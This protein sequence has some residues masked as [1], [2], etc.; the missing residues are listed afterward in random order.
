VEDRLRPERDHK[1]VPK[2]CERVT[3]K[4]VVLRPVSEGLTEA[5]GEGFDGIMVVKVAGQRV[6]SIPAHDGRSSYP[7]LLL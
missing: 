6:T 4:C 7:T 5:A 3:V 1:R 2:D